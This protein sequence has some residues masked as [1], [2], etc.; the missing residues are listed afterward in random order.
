V[1][2]DSAERWLEVGPDGPATVVRILRSEVFH[3]ETIDV[4]GEELARL[5]KNGSHN[6]ILHLGA[7]KRVSSHMI[8]ELISLQKKARAA[9]GRLALCELTPELNEVF[10]LLGL[11]KVFSIY[12]SEDDAMVSFQTW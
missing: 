3:E 5:L 10:N 12:D 1:A 7:V 4:L 9:S 8:G 11:R 6:L 2:E